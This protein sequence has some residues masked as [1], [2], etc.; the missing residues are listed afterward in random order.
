MFEII[1]DIKWKISH[2]TKPLMNQRVL[3]SNK[4]ILSHLV[5]LT[6]QLTIKQYALDTINTL[7]VRLKR[8]RPEYYAYFKLC[9][10]S[11]KIQN[12]Y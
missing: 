12:I 4:G 2:R 1:S 10:E 8:L 7:P 5:K 3:T 9:L 6:T 11:K